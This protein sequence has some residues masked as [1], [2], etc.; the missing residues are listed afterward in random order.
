[1]SLIQHTYTPDESSKR[2]D[3]GSLDWWKLRVY[4][5]TSGYEAWKVCL[6]KA[7][8]K[9]SF[10]VP[11]LYVCVSLWVCVL[12][13]AN[14]VCVCLFVGVCVSIYLSIYLRANTVYVCVHVCVCPAECQ[15]CTCTRLMPLLL[16]APQTQM[17]AKLPC[18]WQ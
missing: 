1:M 13:S 10:I 14:T 5:G 4:T 16:T 9:R 11:T 15:H 18:A 6:Q 2:H 7:F 3:N 12:H 17:D 8:K